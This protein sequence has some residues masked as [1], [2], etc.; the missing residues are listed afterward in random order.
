[1]CTFTPKEFFEAPGVIGTNSVLIT[2]GQQRRVLDTVTTSIYGNPTS[3]YQ[4]GMNWIQ[5]QQNCCPPCLQQNTLQANAQFIPGGVIFTFG[6]QQVQSQY[7]AVPGF[8]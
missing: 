4:T 8:A 5:N 6:P 1:M 3:S 7:T 2:Q